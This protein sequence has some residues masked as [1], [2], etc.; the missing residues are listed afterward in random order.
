MAA[1]A[2]LATGA[3]EAFIRFG[4]VSRFNALGGGGACFAPRQRQEINFRLKYLQL[5]AARKLEHA[6]HEL[7]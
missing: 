2:R 3:P 7:I 6:R 5:S 4:R 1:E